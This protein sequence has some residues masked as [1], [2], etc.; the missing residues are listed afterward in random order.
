MC[1][2]TKGT[3]LHSYIE[4]VRDDIFGIMQC[5]KD[6]EG[7]DLSEYSHQLNNDITTMTHYFDKG[8][9]SGKCAEK[10]FE[11]YVNPYVF[12]PNLLKGEC[13]HMNK[14]EVTFEGWSGTLLKHKPKHKSYHITTHVNAGSAEEAIR[15]TEDNGYVIERNVIVREFTLT[16]RLFLAG[17]YSS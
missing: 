10:L 3:K 15:Q 11:L 7:M 9:E 5:F 4:N 13:K 1:K 14:Y 8:I 17:N 2:S 16:D 12:W 6:D